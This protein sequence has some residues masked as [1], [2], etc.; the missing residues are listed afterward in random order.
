MSNTGI[1]LSII[2]ISYNTLEITRECLVSLY[3]NTPECSFEVIL[4]DN[5]S[6]D[7]SWEMVEKEFSDV[8]LIKNNDN[9]GFAAANNQGFEIAKG[10]Q[11]LLLNSDTVVLGDV[12]QQSVGYLVQHS[13]IGAMG[14]R[15]LNT[16]RSTQLTCSMFPSNLNLL[17]MTLRL[18]RLKWPKFFGRYHMRD[19]DRDSVRDVDVISGCYLLI[20][21]EI[22]QTIG[23]LDEDFFFFGEETEWCERIRAAGW[24]LSFAPVGEIIH[25]GGASAKKLNYKR[26]LMLTGATILLHEKARSKLSAIGCF[27]VLMAFNLSRAI[28]W[29]IKAM[30]DANAKSR[31]LH[32][33]NVTYRIFSTWPKGIRK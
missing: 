26:D 16:D 3:Q 23:G 9:R 12:L 33:R 6:H 28:I 32:F 8:I 25:H 7:G 17:I 19:W 2:I 18:D 27:F 11:V 30:F 10:G 15:V 21:T 29:T 24:R 13:D 5:D 4:V 31:A 20:R 1:D 22:L 14:C